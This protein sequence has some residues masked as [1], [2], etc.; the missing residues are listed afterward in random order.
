MCVRSIPVRPGS[1]LVR[2]VLFS[3]PRGSL[4]SV[5]YGRSLHSRTPRGSRVHSYAFAPFPCALSGSF[6]Y[7]PVHP[8]FVGSI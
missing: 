2:S 5:P 7:V 4:G 6:E 1:R 8:A 3:A